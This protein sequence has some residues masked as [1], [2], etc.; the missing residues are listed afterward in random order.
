MTGQSA[1]PRNTVFDTFP[2]PQSATKK[3]IDAVAAAKISATP[4]TAPGTPVTSI[5]SGIL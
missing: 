3:Q 5:S 4:V 1:H 2:W